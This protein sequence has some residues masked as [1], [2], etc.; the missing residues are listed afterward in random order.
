MNTTFIAMSLAILLGA[1]LLIGIGALSLF[2]GAFNSLFVK[3]KLQI[4]KS[5]YGDNGFAFSFV[6]NKS[7]GP[8]K[9]DR[10]R[11]QLFNPFGSPKQLEVTRNFVGS[12]K[13]FA[14]DLN[15]GHVIRDLLLAEGIDDAIVEVEVTSL[16]NC[17]THI[18]SMNGK[19]FKEKYEAATFT[20][21]EMNE[22]FAA[23]SK[24]KIVEIPAV[25]EEVKA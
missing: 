8:F 17:V 19:T 16:K 25:K 9:F 23:V 14:R 15:L 11:I 21:A 18:F 10:L 1:G 4:L 24:Q 3:P 7:I 13:D 6:W 12:D 20:A 22:Q 5:Q 2:T